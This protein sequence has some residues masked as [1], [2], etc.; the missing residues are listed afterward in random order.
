MSPVRHNRKGFRGHVTTDAPA[1]LLVGHARDQQIPDPSVAPLAVLVGGMLG[2]RALGRGHGEAAPA[3]VAPHPAQ[4]CHH[5][6]DDVGITPDVDRFAEAAVVLVALVAAGSD[7]GDRGSVGQ[8]RRRT[9]SLQS[10]RVSMIEACSAAA[11]DVNR[12]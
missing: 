4:D 7:G 10:A 2:L 8:L 11:S 9:V 1:S 6:V 12:M 3:P 5:R